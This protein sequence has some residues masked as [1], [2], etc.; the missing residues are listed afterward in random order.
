M[1]DTEN[2][3]KNVSEVVALNPLKDIIEELY[4]INKIQRKTS[5][6]LSKRIPHNF[7]VKKPEI[8]VVPPTTSPTA[9]IYVDHCGIDCRADVEESRGTEMKIPRPPIIEAIRNITSK[10]SGL[11]F[12]IIIKGLPRAAMTYRT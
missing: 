9:S 3:K 5:P 12:T 8:A 2:A 6:A 7:S 1:Q 10:G 4:T 11:D